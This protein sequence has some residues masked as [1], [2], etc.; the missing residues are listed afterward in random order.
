MDRELLVAHSGGNL[1]PKRVLFLKTKENPQ[2]S[3][4]SFWKRGRENV[5]LHLMLLRNSSPEKSLQKNRSIFGLKNPSGV[6]ISLQYRSK[7]RLY[8]E[9]I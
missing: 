9:R 1:L 2:I 5:F 8:L 3:N 4:A 6:I 7:K